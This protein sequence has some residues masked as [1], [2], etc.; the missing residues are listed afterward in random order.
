MKSVA[1]LLAR[2]KEM[3]A[4]LTALTGKKDVP[5]ADQP[6]HLKAVTDKL[7]E[8]DKANADLE[9]AKRIEAA[10]AAA[11]VPANAPV[12]ANVKSDLT[13][14]EKIGII[15]SGMVT[16]LA[17]EGT[18]GFKPAMRAIEAN[19][20]AQLAHEIDGAQ[21]HRTMNSATAATGG[22]LLPETMSNDII[23]MLRPNNTY[24]QGGPSVIPMPNGS[25]KQ[26]KQAT[27]A[28]AAYRGET[29]PASV[30]ELT[31]KGISMTAKLLAGIVPLSNQLI[32]WSGPDVGAF[33]QNDLSMAMGDAMDYNAYFGDG[34]VDTPLGLFNIPDI[35]STA[36]PSGVTAPTYT[37]VDTAARLLKTPMESYTTLLQKVEWRMA[38]R[39]FDYL[40]DMRDGLGN[41][42]YPTLSAASPTWKGYPARKTTQFP[43]N[44]GAGTNESYI[45]LIAFGH[46][47]FGDAMRMQLAISDVA[48]VVNGSQTINSFQDG[49]TVIKAES[50]HDF[51][52]RYPEAVQLLTG[53]KWG[54]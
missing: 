36:E 23:V 30:S 16:A 39:V 13:S 12:A 38:P 17:E 47:L 27:G 7:D 49:V 44:L 22:I 26:P 28:T 6:A 43:T 1:E 40:A 21:K 50:E 4:E 3:Y 35:G 34:L 32:R 5:E 37:Q 8:I 9:V 29:R 20:Y 11:A 45:A 51:D 24:L 52:V 2:L 41:L 14:A 54:A 15:V 53:V 25:Y 10:T 46:T 42:I 19:G 31:F 33:A 48:T 18:R